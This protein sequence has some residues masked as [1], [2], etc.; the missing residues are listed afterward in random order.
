MTDFIKELPFGTLHGKS[1]GK[2]VEAYLGVPYAQPPVNNLRWKPPVKLEKSDAQIDC[3]ELGYSAMQKEDPVMAASKRQQSE[4]CLTLNIW[5]RSD[6]QGPL[7][8]MVYLH[9]GAYLEGGSSDPLYDGTNF[10][11]EHDVVFVTVNYRDGGK[12]LIQVVDISPV[13][14]AGRSTRSPAIWALWIR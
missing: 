14:R 5:R 1:T 10:A 4:D 7:P 12:S 9:G 11:S 13:F 6:A 3:T 2:G 8:V